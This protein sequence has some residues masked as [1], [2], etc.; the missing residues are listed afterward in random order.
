MGTCQ[1]SQ[2]HT[3]RDNDAS[4]IPCDPA[5]FMN[6]QPTSCCTE[7]L[8]QFAASHKI[9]LDES[10]REFLNRNERILGELVLGNLVGMNRF[11]ELL[12]GLKSVGIS[13][14]LKTLH[15]FVGKKYGEQIISVL[16]RYDATFRRP[17]AV[18]CD[19]LIRNGVISS[20]EAEKWMTS[21][22]FFR[23]WKDVCY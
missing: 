21:L 1:L 22:P 19:L 5:I 16:I 18:I 15:D 13:T 4:E 7:T 17:T 10:R 14:M 23:L 8:P 6:S 20:D 9:S 12:L 2:F 3:I 11:R